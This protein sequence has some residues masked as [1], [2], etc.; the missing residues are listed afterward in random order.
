MRLRFGSSPPCVRVPPLLRGP[1]EEGGPVTARAAWSS[2]LEYLERTAAHSL[3]GNGLPY[4]IVPLN[5]YL[6][7]LF[8]ERTGK[9]LDINV[10]EGHNRMSAHWALNSGE[11]E[12]WGEDLVTWV[13][14]NVN[15]LFVQCCFRIFFRVQVVLTAGIIITL[16]YGTRVIAICDF[17]YLLSSLPLAFLNPSHL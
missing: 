9:K 2:L 5:D 6:N 3:N 17:S 7:T 16:G 14:N 1:G 8:E 10:G 11:G 13:K 15:E 12:R 4:V